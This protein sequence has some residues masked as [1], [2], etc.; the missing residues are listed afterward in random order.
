VI[1]L[2]MVIEGF[3]SLITNHVI[4]EK[5]ERYNREAMIPPNL[6]GSQKYK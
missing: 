6:G 3:G 2:L 5:I 1:P 4:K